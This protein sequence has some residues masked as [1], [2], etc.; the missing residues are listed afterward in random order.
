MSKPPQLEQ[1]NASYDSVQDRLL[2]RVRSSDDAEFRFW[3]TRR[4]LGLLWPMLMKMADTFSALKAP[5][6]LLTR[7][8][9]AELAHG[10]A[11]SKADFGS[12][13]RDG[14]LFPLGEEPILLARITVQALQGDT[15]TL[16]LLPQE[17]Q[18]I[19]LALDE[20]L[21]HV[22]A[23][24]LQEAATAAEWG[25]SLRVTPGSSATPEATEAA[26]PRLLH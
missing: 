4:Y 19:N 1:F 9:L 15:Q 25:L 21:V 20:K 23:R 13:Y 11:V 3:I 14:S 26:A 2:L 6:D 12:T 22:L 16:T 17:G 7:N 10:E 8:T 18:G 24:L 5:G